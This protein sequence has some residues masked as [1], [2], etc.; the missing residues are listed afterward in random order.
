MTNITRR[1]KRTYCW[2]YV[3]CAEVRVKLPDESARATPLYWIGCSLLRVQE[4]GWNRREYPSENGADCGWRAEQ[5]D[6]RLLSG[7]TWSWYSSRRQY[8]TTTD[9]SHPIGCH[10]NH[11]GSLYIIRC[12]RSSITG[13]SSRPGRRPLRHMEASLVSGYGWLG[14]CGLDRQIELP[15]R[16]LHRVRIGARFAHRSVDPFEVW[17]AI[18]LLLRQS[19]CLRLGSCTLCRIAAI[20]QI[21]SHLRIFSPEH[22]RK[23]CLGVYQRH[24]L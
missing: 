21:C 2:I 6:R 5:T 14:S 9:T 10:W 22:H 3:L 16:P 13:T 23:V 24:S 19:V 11:W 1:Q 4:L 7:C 12:L 15:N 8:W 17:T 18:G 20:R